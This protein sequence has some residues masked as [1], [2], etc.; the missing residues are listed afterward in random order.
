L[1]ASAAAAH[2]VVM[3]RRQSCKPVGTFRQ[4]SLSSVKADIMTAKANI[5]HV[6]GRFSRLEV[7]SIPHAMIDRGNLVYEHEI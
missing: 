1:R 5:V 7:V 3:R 4:L 6:H 2:L